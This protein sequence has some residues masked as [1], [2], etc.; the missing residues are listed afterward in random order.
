MSNAGILLA[1][2]A[3]DPYITR[4]MADPKEALKKK[5]EDVDE[6]ALDTRSVKTVRTKR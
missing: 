3:A 5:V 2:R 1:F 4:P 6:M